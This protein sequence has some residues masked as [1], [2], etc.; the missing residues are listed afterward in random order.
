MLGAATVAEV[1][2]RYV[3]IG[4]QV[5]PHEATIPLNV[6]LVSSDEAARAPD[7]EVIEEVV[8]L[9]SAQVQ[10]EARTRARTGD[11]DGAQRLLRDTAKDL[12]KVAPGSPRGEELEQQAAEMEEHAT[13]FATEG[14]MTSLQ[15]KRMR[16]ESWER[17]RKRR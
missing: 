13:R 5:A 9:K 6:N 4:D 17:R 3:T 14:E 16:Y 2:L 15:A 10:E 12:R 7:T 11:L 8:I 1:V